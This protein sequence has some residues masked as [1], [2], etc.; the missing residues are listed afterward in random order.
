MKKVKYASPELTGAWVLGGEWNNILINGFEEV[1]NEYGGKPYKFEKFVETFKWFVD[2]YPNI[3][4]D[5][6]SRSVS[7]TTGNE[8]VDDDADEYSPVFLT[9]RMPD[10]KTLRRWYD[11]HQKAMEYYAG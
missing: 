5:P 3:T 9:L 7:M 4:Y 1:F 8:Y 10:R 2:E 6:M 11:D